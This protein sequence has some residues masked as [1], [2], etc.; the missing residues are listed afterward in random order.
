LKSRQGFRPHSY[1][2]YNTF[3]TVSTWLSFYPFLSVHIILLLTSTGQKGKPISMIDG[4]NDAL[5]PK[6]VSFGV[7]LKK[8]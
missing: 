3:L 2:K 6:E 4:S 1:V 7:S 5:P 8:N